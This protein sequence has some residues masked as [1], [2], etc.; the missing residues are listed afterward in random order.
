MPRAWLL[1]S[2]L[3]AEFNAK[4]N[5]CFD[6]GQ[7]GRS[8]AGAPVKLWISVLKGTY[9]YPAIAQSTLTP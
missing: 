7:D 4:L 9:G 1:A 2:G 3:T 8:S 5:A 6:F